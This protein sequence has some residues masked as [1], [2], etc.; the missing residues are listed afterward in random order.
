MKISIIENKKKEKKVKFLLQKSDSGYANTIRRIMISEIPTMAIEDVEIKSNDS[1]LYDQ[2]IALRLGL[3]PLTTDLKAYN[4]PKDCICKGAGC[5]RCQLKLTLKEIGPKTVYS[6]DMKSKDPKV[7]PV[8]D[9]IP[10]VE[11][12]EGQSLEFEATAILGTGKEH[13]KWSPCL[14]YYTN[15]PLIK[16][17]KQPE[18]PNK[19]IE[20]CPKKIFEIKNNKLSIN[21]KKLIECDLCEACLETDNENCIELEHKEDEFIFTIESWGQ[22][23]TNEIIEESINVLNK[24][25]SE[26]KKLIN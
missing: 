1:V 3:I 10:I 7:K 5:A 9:K 14:A 25:L 26:F 19:I 15:Y 4:V 23:N 2:M 24:K 6:K 16:I 17:K 22:L 13:T 8:Y 18:D 11:L 20:K 21:D 12:L